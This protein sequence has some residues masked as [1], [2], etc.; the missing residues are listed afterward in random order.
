VR[1][2]SCLATTA[3][4]VCIRSTSDWVS[5]AEPGFSRFS[6]EMTPTVTLLVNPSGLPITSQ[7][8]ARRAVTTTSYDHRLLA[9]GRSEKIDG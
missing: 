7:R 8:K 5:D 9:N 1:R 2:R 3:A 6:L 4:S